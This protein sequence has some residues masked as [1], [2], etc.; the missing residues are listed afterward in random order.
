MARDIKDSINYCIKMKSEFSNSWKSSKQPR[1]QRKYLFNSPIKI[2]HKFLSAHLTREL[3][4]KYNRRS[5]PLRKGDEVKILRGQFRGKKGKIEDVDL[6]NLKVFIENIQH[7]KNDGTKTF[8][9]LHPSNLIIT[10]LNLTDK[11]RRAIFERKV[12]AI[13][14]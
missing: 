12:G 2:R 3:I 11:K 9:P 1:K 6:K 14:K 8:F 7:T 13:K 5:I 10:D 4:K